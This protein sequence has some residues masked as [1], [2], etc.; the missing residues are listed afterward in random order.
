[1]LGVITENPGER[2]QLGAWRTLGALLASLPVGMILPALIYDENNNVMGKKLFVISIVMGLIAV[3]AFRFMTSTTVQRVP[4]PV[5]GEDAPKTS[6]LDSI[7]NFAKNRPA[8][9]VTLLPVD[10]YLGS[11]GAATAVVVMFQSYFH[12]AA[13]SGLLS[14]AII[15]PMIAFIPLAKVITEKFGKKES[16]AV[17]YVVSMA[18]CLLLLVLPVKPDGSGVL[19]YMVLMIISS[20]GASAGSCFMNAMMA[21]AIDYNE[22]KTGKREEGTTYA[23][24]NFF[25]KLAQGVG[26]SFG[27]VL[28]VA[29]GYNE[30]L[31]A[32]QP[33]EDALKMRYLVAALYLAGAVLQ[34]IGAKL[35]YNLDK[36]TLAQIETELK[37]K[38]G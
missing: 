18:A 28:M 29:L 21:D 30:Q 17:G 13:I 5:Q 23:L 38:R 27:L 16:S 32:T 1:M 25:R 3:A 2:A 12:N 24:H 9:G 34:F 20:F 6:M 7:K 31:G 33:F 10:Q 36:K 14:L 22:W 35:V 37:E 19:M 8:I 11:Y 4:T 15:V 26:P